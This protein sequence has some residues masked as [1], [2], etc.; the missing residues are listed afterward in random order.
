VKVA[1]A[2]PFFNQLPVVGHITKKKRTQGLSKRIFGDGAINLPLTVVPVTKKGLMRETSNNK[3]HIK[4]PCCALFFYA[5]F[6]TGILSDTE[7]KKA[8]HMLP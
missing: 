6:S 5:S 3:R 8:S 7:Y 2:I 1:D 4:K